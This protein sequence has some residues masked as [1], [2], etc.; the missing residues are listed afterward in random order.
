MS[1]NKKVSSSSSVLDIKKEEVL[2]KP[3]YK[4]CLMKGVDPLDGEYIDWKLD[5]KFDVIAPQ[6]KKDI[7]EEILKEVKMEMNENFEEL[8]KEY[9]AKF[10]IS[11]SDEDI[12]DIGGHGQKSE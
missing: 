11:F 7:K 8:K 12:I 5:E 3:T 1:K 2:N 10:D 9:N 4:K 6:W